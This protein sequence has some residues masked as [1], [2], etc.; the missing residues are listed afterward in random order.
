MISAKRGE[1]GG[2]IFPICTF[3]YKYCE[4]LQAKRRSKMGISDVVVNELKIDPAFVLSPEFRPKPVEVLKELDGIPVIDLAPLLANDEK[5]TQII[6][7]QIAKASEE[8]GF[9]QL[10]NHGIPIKLLDDVE[11]EALKFFSLPLEEK[12]KIRRTL[13]HPL[14][15]FDTEL[16]QNVRDWKEVFDFVTRGKLEFAAADGTLNVQEN[17]WPESPPFL[18]DVCEAW[19]EATLGVA[20]KILELLT[21]SLGLPATYFNPLFDKEDTN[22]MRL[23]YYPPCPAPDL[24]LGVSGHKDSGALTVLVQDEVGGLEVRRKDGEWIRVKPRRDALIINVGDLFQVWSNDR[25]KS[26]EHRVV[27]N[28]HKERSSI[29]LFIN[30]SNATNVFPIPELLDAQ[31]PPK[32]R[33][34]NWGDFLQALKTSHFKNMRVENIQISHLAINS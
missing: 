30:P 11:V 23:N 10:I 28:E 8:W 16:T 6:V 21:L 26:V 13:E 29:P 34:Y 25:Y 5:G 3:I 9:F 27:V 14:G 1:G 4:S 19:K 7:E 18:K 22:F 2:D 12:R 31:H 17:K 15:Y 24:V 20:Y 33:Q 32:Y